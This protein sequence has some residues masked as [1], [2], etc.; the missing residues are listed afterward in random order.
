MRPYSTS[1]GVGEVPSELI[2]EGWTTVSSTC[3][4]GGNCKQRNEHEQG[5][6]QVPRM[7]SRGWEVRLGPKHEGP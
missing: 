3:C 6:G 5:H 4:Q 7:R 2:F 1:R